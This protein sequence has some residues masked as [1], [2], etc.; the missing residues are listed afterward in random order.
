VAL[1][2]SHPAA[3]VEPIRRAATLREGVWQIDVLPLPISGRWQVRVDVLVGDF[4]KRVLEA[5]MDIR[6]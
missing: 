5:S 2:L 6:P 4:E 3:G 1:I